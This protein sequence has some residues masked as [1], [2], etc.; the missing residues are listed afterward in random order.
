MHEELLRR[1]Y[2]FPRQA[3]ALA[4]HDGELYLPRDNVD[5]LVEHGYAGDFFQGLSIIRDAGFRS[6]YAPL[7]E[8][9][10]AAHEAAR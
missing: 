8:A 5:L 3:E 9:V 6:I 10:A 1:G 7:E 4:T 2:T